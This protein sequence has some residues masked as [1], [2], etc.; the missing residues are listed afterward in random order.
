MHEVYSDHGTNVI[1][2]HLEIYKLI[3]EAFAQLNER[4]FFIIGENRS[5]DQ[6]LYYRE[7]CIGILRRF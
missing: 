2:F 4:A 7:K 6:M 3:E 1:R 5:I